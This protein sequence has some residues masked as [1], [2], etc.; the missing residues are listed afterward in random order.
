MFPSSSDPGLFRAL[1]GRGA[2][3][4]FMASCPAHDDRNPSLH[5]TT[6]KDGGTLVHCFAGCTQDAVID[7]LRDK[8]LWPEQPR[9]ESRKEAKR[10]TGEIVAKYDYIAADGELAHQTLRLEPKSFRQRRPAPES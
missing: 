6:T 7:A 4:D 9:T 1:N 3:H 10:Q 2:P 8:G 5:V